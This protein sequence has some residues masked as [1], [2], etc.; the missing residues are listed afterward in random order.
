M[1]QPCRRDNTPAGLDNDND[2]ELGHVRLRL[3]GLGIRAAL[4]ASIDILTHIDVNERR[5]A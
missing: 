3:L 5:F 2:A 1:N 4:H